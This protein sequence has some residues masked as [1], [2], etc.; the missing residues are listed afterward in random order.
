MGSANAKGKIERF[1]R[2]VRS[3]FLS[4]LKSEDLVDI[5][6]LNEKFAAWLDDDYQRKPHDGIGGACPL[7]VFLSQSKYIIFVDNLAEFSKKF[8][9]RV[10][11]TVKK[12]AT[13]SLSGDLYETDMALSG[14]R[15]EAHYDPDGPGGIR[16]L[17]LFKDGDPVGAAKL[18][19]HVANSKRKRRGGKE[20]SGGKAHNGRD[21]AAEGAAIRKKTNTIPYAD[22]KERWQ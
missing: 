17:F 19:D 5:E 13:I 22:M 2:T 20:P 6:A 11:R 8:M 12:D 21:D 3:R 15:V 9:I 10:M 7:D 4:R 18:V 1:F 14:M 16:E